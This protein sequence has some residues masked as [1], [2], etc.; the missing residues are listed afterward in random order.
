M[1]L[2][3]EVFS[4]PKGVTFGSGKFSSSRLENLLKDK[5]KSK[6]GDENTKMIDSDNSESTC[7]M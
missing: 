3:K 2:V 7:K 4:K 5:I 6:L 1:H